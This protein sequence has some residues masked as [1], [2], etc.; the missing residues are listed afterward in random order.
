VADEF[1]DACVPFP[2]EAWAAVE[3]LGYRPPSKAIREAV[4]AELR[5]R[6]DADLFE[7]AA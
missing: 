6:F 3:A 7:E 5:E 2:S 4:I 1:G